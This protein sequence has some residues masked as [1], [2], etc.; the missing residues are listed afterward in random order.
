MK[1]RVCSIFIVLLFLPAFSFDLIAQERIEDDIQYQNVSLRRAIEI[2]F[3]SNII[4][5]EYL[6]Y[7]SLPRN[8]ELNHSGYPVVYLLDAWAVF[9]ETYSVY[10]ILN[11][12]KEIPDLMIV[13][14]SY[15]G[16]LQNWLNNRKLDLTPNELPRDSNDN[17][18]DG[19]DSGRGEM[20]LNF[21]TEELI[22]YVE[23]NYRTLDNDRTLIGHSRG[24]FFGFYTLFNKPG[25][26]KRFILGSPPIKIAGIDLFQYEEDFFQNNNSIIAKVFTAKGSLEKTD[27]WER[28]VNKLRKRNYKN[29]ELKVMILEDETHYSCIPSILVKGLKY[30]FK[31]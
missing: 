8:Y 18:L 4:D 12:A 25:T 16:D 24:A 6:L 22:P 23:S 21:I 1:K 10:N 26:F 29:L 13:G 20:F 31:E 7:I 3:H 17:S 15:R 9:Y 30:I 11:F 14:I 2:P 27:K 28:F 5:E 19:P